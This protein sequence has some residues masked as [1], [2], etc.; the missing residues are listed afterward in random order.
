V[1]NNLLHDDNAAEAITQLAEEVS[2]NPGVRYLDHALATIANLPA[3]DFRELGESDVFLAQS[4]A[5]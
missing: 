3:K 2:F 4:V 5:R 1:V